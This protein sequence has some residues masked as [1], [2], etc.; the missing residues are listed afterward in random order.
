MTEIE[1]QAFAL[2]KVCDLHELLSYDPE[3]GILIWEKK[4]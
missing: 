4:P 2:V 3:T 1:K